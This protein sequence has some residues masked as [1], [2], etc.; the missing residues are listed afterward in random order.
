MAT[1]TIEKKSK[2]ERFI[3][4]VELR[5][6]RILDDL[7]KLGKCSSRKN[8]DYSDEDVR[9]IFSAIERKVKEIKSMFQGNPKERFKL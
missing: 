6:N 3:K 4:V 2:R 5:V 1:K 9:K 7:D 8:Y